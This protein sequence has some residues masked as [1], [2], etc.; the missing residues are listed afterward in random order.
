MRDG[1]HRAGKPLGEARGR[2]DPTKAMRRPAP[3][4]FDIPV[5]ACAHLRRLGRHVHRHFERGAGAQRHSGRPMSPRL[6]ASA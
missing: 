2:R 1:A 5:T 6:R 3:K 4:H